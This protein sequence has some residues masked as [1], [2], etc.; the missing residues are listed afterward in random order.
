M[1]TLNAPYIPLIIITAIL[2]WIILGKMG[3]GILAKIG[4]MLA[5]L[6]PYTALAELAFLAFFPWPNG[7]KQTKKRTS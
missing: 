2:W 7:Q 3:F 1:R 4:L 6:T 5:C